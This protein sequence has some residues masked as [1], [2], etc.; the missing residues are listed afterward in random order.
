M[1]IQIYY[2][3]DSNP[4]ANALQV[5]NHVEVSDNPLQTFVALPSLYSSGFLSS[6]HQ[7][8]RDLNI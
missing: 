3:K 2:T 7:H 6:L 8:L 5:V 4:I 1:I